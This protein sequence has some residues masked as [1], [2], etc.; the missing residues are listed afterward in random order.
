MNDAATRPWFKDTLFVFVADHTSDGRGNTDLP[1]EKFRIP[2]IIYSPENVK[3]AQVDVVASQIDVGPT[4]LAL[5][6][7][8]YTS[9]FFGQ[10][11]MTEGQ[12]HP[13]ALMS[14]YLTVGYLEGGVLVE[15]SP[16]RQS[17]VRDSDGRVLAASD[18]RA[19]TSLRETIAYFQVASDVLKAP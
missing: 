6:N 9:R 13:R 18:P 15:L 10:D 3:P 17:R 12:H 7:V 19:Q 8:S 4:L 14:N 2:M 16:K 5:L 1:R 11:I